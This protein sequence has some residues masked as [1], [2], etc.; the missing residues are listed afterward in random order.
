M[1]ARE[2]RSRCHDRAGGVASTVVA[3]VITRAD[4]VVGLT[5]LGLSAGDR[6]MVH[7]SL[8]SFG[9]VEGGAPTVIGALM[10]V[11][12]D[13]GLLL[14]PSFNHFVPF[15]RGQ[16]GYYSPAEARTFNGTIPE[17]FRRMS[18]VWRSLSP[19]HPFAAWGRQAEGL[20]CRHHLTLTMGSDSPLG[21]LGQEGGYGLFLGTDYTTNTY[22]HVVETTLNAPCLGHRTEELPVVLPS[23]ETL[24]LRTW[25]YRESGC[26]ISDPNDPVDTEM[27]AQGLHRRARIGRAI[28]TLFRLVDCFEVLSAMFAHG[29]GGHPP[30]CECRIRAWASPHQVESDWDAEGQCLLPW[31]PSRDVPPMAYRRP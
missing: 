12:T 10:D 20:L 1:S 31:S 9:R 13:E 22:K 14:M 23:G 8:S 4:I 5:D 29:H 27:A 15:K 16:C 2:V 21:R 6:A 18:G 30:C 7:S 3:P 28:V 19:T 25:S 17:T 11:L 24:K 26:P